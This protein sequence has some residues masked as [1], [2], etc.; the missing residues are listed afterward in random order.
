VAIKTVVSKYHPKICVKDLT[1]SHASLNA[2]VVWYEVKAQ[3]I[4]KAYSIEQT[5]ALVP[6]RLIYMA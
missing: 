1:G 4:A 5:G 6:R 2:F 3:H